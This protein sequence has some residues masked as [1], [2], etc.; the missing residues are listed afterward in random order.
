MCGQSEPLCQWLAGL[1]LLEAKEY[2]D[3]LLILTGED[4]QF[5]L[6]RSVSVSNNTTFLSTPLITSQHILEG[7]TSR[8]VSVSS[9]FSF[10]WVGLLNEVSSPQNNHVV[11]VW[12]GF[13]KEMLVFEGFSREGWIFA[14][15]WI[16]PKWKTCSKMSRIRLLSLL[17]PQF[18]FI[19]LIQL[20]IVLFAN[21][22]ENWLNLL[23]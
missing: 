10:F 2:S 19:Q 16:L 6:S 8:A 5:G 4:E 17:H 13:C 11:C 22:N 9:Q 1:A 14:L 7:F 12:P 15:D 18:D 20:N 3:A 21:R 23:Q